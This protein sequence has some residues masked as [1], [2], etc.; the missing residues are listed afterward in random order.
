MNLTLTLVPVCVTSLASTTT[1]LPSTLWITVTLLDV[2]ASNVAST[3]F[4]GDATLPSGSENSNR[5]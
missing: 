2:P 3:G 4:S 5:D 1:H